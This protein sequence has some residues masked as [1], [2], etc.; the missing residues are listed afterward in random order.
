MRLQQQ[1]QV[2]TAR[3][4]RFH[5]LRMR[6]REPTTAHDASKTHPRLPKTASRRPKTC[7]RHA[8]EAPRAPKKHRGAPRTVHDAPKTR[9]RR[10]MTRRKCDPD[11]PGRPEDDTRRAQ[12]GLQATQGVPKTR[13]RA[14]RG[15][16][17]GP[18]ARPAAHRLTFGKPV[19]LRSLA[20]MSHRNGAWSP[21]VASQKPHS[22][23]SE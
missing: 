14:H 20:P 10:P 13:R 23:P 2:A 9:S 8:Q 4:C 12:C 5:R 1:D 17:D 21:T 3:F 11:R 7:P 18:K 6:P 19:L 22:S 16:Q 15:A